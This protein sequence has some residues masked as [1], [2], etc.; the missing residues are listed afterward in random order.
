MTIVNV[1]WSEQAVN[2]FR[3]QGFKTLEEFAVKNPNGVYFYDSVV[4][5]TEAEAKAYIRGIN[6]CDG[7]I[8]PYAEIAK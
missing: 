4:F 2:I 6:D 5:E 1:A 3:D 8:E 7:W